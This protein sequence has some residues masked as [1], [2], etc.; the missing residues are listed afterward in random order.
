MY[1]DPDES[2][3]QEAIKQ[4]FLQK[5]LI[6][7]VQI[8]A[9]DG[10]D[11]DPVR[12]IVYSDS[13]IKGLLVEPQQGAFSRLQ[14]TYKPLIESGRVSLLNKAVFERE[15]RVKLYKN[16]AENGTDGHSS[17]LLRQ[18]D[19]YTHFQDDVYEEVDAITVTQLLTIANSPID[20]LVVDTEG[21]DSTIVQCLLDT[22][23]R[24]GVLFFERPSIILADD[25][26]GNVATGLTV[27]NNIVANLQE[28]GYTVEVL[29][30][31]ILGTFN[32]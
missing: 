7:L 10:V 14:Q 27:L 25:R 28:K 3:L 12:E 19:P 24:P 32:F 17:F 6:T 9:N 20:V 2:K 26:L 31:N 4:H 8:G 15:C 22:R 18:N 1:T 21:Y 13:R 30:G 5:E 29:S 23:S 16:A 11:H